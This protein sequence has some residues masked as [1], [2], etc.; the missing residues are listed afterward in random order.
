VGT[1]APYDA[2][3]NWGE[4][5]AEVTRIGRDANIPASRL[6]RLIQNVVHAN[7]GRTE[8]ARG[9]RQGA[10]GGAG[11]AAPAR[12]VAGRLANFIS[13]VRQLGFAEAAKRAGLG[14]L[15]GKPVSEVLNALL[16][17][18]GG[19]SSSID[20]ADA[21]QA[22]SDLQEELLAQAQTVEEVEA[23]LLDE[24]LSFENLLERF[25]GHYIFEQFSRVFYER[26]VQRVGAL[27][28]I[29]FLGQ[30]KE[31]IQSSLAGRA[32]ERDLSKVDWGGA[33]GANIVSEVC[34][35]TLEV[36]GA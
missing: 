5:K 1:S 14:D 3:P 4:V 19:D 28:A 35:Q 31:F 33:E 17:R 18:L 6:R 30:I 36:F 11:S 24:A 9:G 27:Q 2:P 7:G 20:D 22:L 34:S 15:G 12:A 10:A 13:D 8:M 32:M 23:I 26:L 21:R 29:S 16:D 25:F